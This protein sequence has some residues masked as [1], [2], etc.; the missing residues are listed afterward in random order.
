LARLAPRRLAT[1]MAQAL[2]FDQAATR[3]MMTCAASNSATRTDA[4]D[5]GQKLQVGDVAGDVKGHDLAFAAGKDLVSAGEPL[6][7]RAAL[8]GLVLVTD[9]IRVGWTPSVIGGGGSRMS[10]HAIAGAADGAT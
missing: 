8:R 2:S 1:F 7:D 10:G 5:H 6:E 4:I 3:V 9:H